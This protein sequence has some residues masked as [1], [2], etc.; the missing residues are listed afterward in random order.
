MQ[1]PVDCCDLI[2]LKSV[3]ARLDEHNVAQHFVIYS[4]VD[5]KQMNTE[6]YLH[7]TQLKML[8]KY[9]CFS[10]L[11]LILLNEPMSFY[12]EYKFVTVQKLTAIWEV[13][14]IKLE[15]NIK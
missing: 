7:I 15:G 1:I 3:S 9:K 12:E 2:E 6:I 5:G 11:P 13:K 10:T 14:E 8:D 4:W